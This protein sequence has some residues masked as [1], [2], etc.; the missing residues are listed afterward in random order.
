MLTCMLAFSGTSAMFSS[1]AEKT[2]EGPNWAAAT[3]HAVR[4]RKSAVK[5]GPMNSIDT[6]IPE[7]RVRHSTND[8]GSGGVW[9]ESDH[10]PE[11]AAR[12]HRAL[13]P[14]NAL[15]VHWCSKRRH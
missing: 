10:V 3:E 5:R 8:S 9:S 7:D 11:P 1:L 4:E 6:R 13:W 12:L 15:L 14:D 2:L